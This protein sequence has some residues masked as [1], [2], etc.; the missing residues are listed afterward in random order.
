MTP[1]Q[2]AT[3]DAI[4]LGT[5]AT[6]SLGVTFISARYQQWVLV[7]VSVIFAAVFLTAAF[8]TRK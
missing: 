2:V 7:E 6:L 3:K 4:I 8:S 5:I 1:I